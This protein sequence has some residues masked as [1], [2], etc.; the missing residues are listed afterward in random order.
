M[1]RNVIEGNDLI[2]EI[3]SFYDNTKNFE[4]YKYLTNN[5]RRVNM[6]FHE[7]SEVTKEQLHKKY[8]EK[9]SQEWK[10]ELESKS[11][12][13]YYRANK[14]KMEEIKEYFNDVDSELYVK[15]RLNSLPLAARINKEN[16]RR[17]RLCTKENED[18]AHF[19]IH[20][21]KLKNIRDRHIDSELLQK[22]KEEII[23]KLLFDQDNIEMGKFIVKILFNTRK[24]L[25]LEDP[26]R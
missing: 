11:S 7:L 6:E 8:Y 1:R 3:V 25:L 9:D 19:L 23:S 4:A 18:I 20:C 15:A 10:Q 16:E 12:L 13:I 21:E 14:N 17:C 26:A 24:K 5:I 22:G 2:Q